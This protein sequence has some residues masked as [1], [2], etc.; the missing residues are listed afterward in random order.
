MS[1]ADGI[2]MSACACIGAMYGEP[3]CGCVMD[4][5]GLPKNTEMREKER[6]RF[7]TEMAAAFAEG[8]FFHRNA[9]EKS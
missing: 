2:S 5:L 6:I 4:R 8:G 3:H 1:M 9:K 7:E